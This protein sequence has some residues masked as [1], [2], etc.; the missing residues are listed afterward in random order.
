MLS[1]NVVDSGRQDKTEWNAALQRLGGDLLQSY[2][3]G[4]FK[5]RHGWSVARVRTETADG[6]G[7]AQVLVRQRGPFSVAYLPRGPAISGGPEAATELL[8]AIDGVCARYRAALLVIEPRDPL[9]AAW[10][11]QGM[12]FASGPRA[13]QTSRT[14]KV[15]LGDDASLLD[16]M[17][18]DTRYNVSY[19]R[20]RG[21]AVERASLEKADVQ[22]F[23]RLLQET[24]ERNGFGIHG[25]AYYEEFLREFGDQA[26]LLFSRV[27]GEVSAALIAARCGEEGRSMYAASSTTQRGRGDTALLRFEAMRWAREQ[28]CTRFDLGGIAPE[29]SATGSQANIKK[30]SRDSQLEGIHQFKTGFGG[31]IVAYPS[32]VSRRYRPVMAWFIRRFHPRFRAEADA[33][34][35]TEPN[36]N[37]FS[38]LRIQW[39]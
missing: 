7:M 14:V 6:E 24:S 21:V 5:H 12:G 32:T 18:K 16:Q 10:V 4:A 38:H 35:G 30:S 20:R 36:E 33:Q 13:F 23:H 37:S 15:P 22:I 39:S 17:R 11:G 25:D 29:T 1:K 3:W 34:R 8:S 2:E 27:E 28:G 19:A 9:P 26:I 31:E